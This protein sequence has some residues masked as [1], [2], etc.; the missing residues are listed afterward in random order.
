[1]D[2][3]LRYV[4]FSLVYTGPARGFLSPTSACCSVP[5][6]IIKQA[7]CRVPQL[8]IVV[9]TQNTRIIL[10]ELLAETTNP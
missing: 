4:Q 5:L 2:V 1:M 8:S 3:L 9:R 7:S 6:V 10:G